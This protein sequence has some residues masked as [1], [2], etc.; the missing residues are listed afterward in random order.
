MVKKDNDDS[1]WQ[2][3]GKFMLTVYYGGEGRMGQYIIKADT[4]GQAI[5]KVV[6]DLLKQWPDAF[7]ADSEI[8]FV[9]EIWDEMK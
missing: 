9:R 1:L 6:N 5:Q 3:D 7:D 2:Q 8:R 4:Y